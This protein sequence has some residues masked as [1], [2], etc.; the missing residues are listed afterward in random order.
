ML[1]LGGGPP[2]TAPPFGPAAQGVEVRATAAS[3]VPHNA[4]RAQAALAGTPTAQTALNA[5]ALVYNP[6][7]TSL[8]GPPAAS[9]TTPTPHQIL[10]MQTPY[11]VP[12]PSSAPASTVYN[13]LP[14]RG[15]IQSEP[16]RTTEL[17]DPNIDPN[18]DDPSQYCTSKAGPRPTSTPSFTTIPG[19][20]DLTAHALNANNANVDGSN[21]SLTISLAQILE[22][23]RTQEA[24]RRNASDVGDTT[25]NHL[26]WEALSVACMGKA[27]QNFARAEWWTERAKKSD[28]GDNQGYLTHAGELTFRK[29]EWWAKEVAIFGMSAAEEAE[30]REHVRG[31]IQL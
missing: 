1:H 3:T 11:G 6:V 31:R 17:L 21:S 18:L 15:D 24:P 10:P 22:R 13:T 20:L 23:E 27:Q 30:H 28:A 4:K 8:A 16:L 9:H 19:S 29:G 26:P 25:P 14:P 7:Y 12:P 5:P 2:V